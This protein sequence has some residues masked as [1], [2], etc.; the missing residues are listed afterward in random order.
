MLQFKARREVDEKEFEGKKSE[1]T[2][3]LLIQKRQSA[4]GEFLAQ[5]RERSEITVEEGF[6]D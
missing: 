6:L 2:S 1:I 4:I 5:L 3:S